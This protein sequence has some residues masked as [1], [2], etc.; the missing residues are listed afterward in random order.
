MQVLDGVTIG[1]DSII[2][3][4]AVVNSDISEYS[5]AVGIPAKVVR[6]RKE[7]REI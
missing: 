1:R 6:S 7:G 4:S 5:I 2:G 3:T